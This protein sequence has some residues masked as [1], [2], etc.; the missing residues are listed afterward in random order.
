MPSILITGANRGIGLELVRQ[1][2]QAGWSVLATVR[3]PKRPS[4]LA[5]LPG[6]IEIF[7]LEAADH[8]SI[9]ALVRDLNGRPIDVLIA[10]AGIPG[11]LTATPEEIT[12]EDFLEVMSVNAFAPLALATALFD[13]IIAGERR[14][15]TAMSS[16]MS[17]VGSNDWGTQYSYRASKTALNAVWRALA[18]EWTP[19]NVACVLLRPGLVATEMSGGRGMPVEESVSGMLKVVDALTLA[20]SGRII[21]FDGLDVPW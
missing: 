19:K 8:R 9:D 13:N 2:A 12:R 21:G 15:V 5:E 3:D 20:D 16:L 10:N 6:N 14:V 1:Y 4:Q 11:Q 18:L 7:A 17:S